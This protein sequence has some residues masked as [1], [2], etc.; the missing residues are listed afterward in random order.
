MKD[1]ITTNGTG[2][3]IGSPVAMA[4]IQQIQGPTPMIEFFIREQAQAKNAG[5]SLRDYLK[6]R[7]FLLNQVAQIKRRR[8]CSTEVDAK[9]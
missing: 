7:E 2:K 8:D 5:L 1:L 9:A 3:K 6:R 4:P